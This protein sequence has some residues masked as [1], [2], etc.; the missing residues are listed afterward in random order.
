MTDSDKSPLLSAT[1]QLTKTKKYMQ[2]MQGG[3]YGIDLT[4]ISTNPFRSSLMQFTDFRMTAGP[5]F[6]LLIPNMFALLVIFFSALVELIALALDGM[7]LK[8]PPFDEPQSIALL[9][10]N[11]PGCAYCIFELI[12]VLCGRLVFSSFWG[13]M[14]HLGV[15]LIF[16]G[17]AFAY[18]L[19]AS[20]VSGSRMSD[21]NGSASATAFCVSDKAYLIAIFAFTL[22]LFF[23]IIWDI[24]WAIM[25]VIF[26]DLQYMAIGMDAKWRSLMKNAEGTGK[27]KAMKQ[28]IILDA[29]ML[30]MDK[31]SSTN[32]DGSSRIS[33][34]AFNFAKEHPAPG[35]YSVSSSISV[36]K[37]KE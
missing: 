22:V 21:C 31:R 10:L 2:G 19:M 7:P 11:I 36:F 25:L 16:G 27:D 14:A 18:T 32:K 26:R 23:V 1:E 15:A 33:E 29:F 20:I 6:S 37:R 13:Q 35:R 12:M 30:N 28:K 4:Q 8:N 3:S 24:L 34:D 17:F 5:F 9:A